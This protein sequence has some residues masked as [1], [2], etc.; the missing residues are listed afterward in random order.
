MIGRDWLRVL[1][2]KLKTE[3]GKCEVNCVNE[4]VNKLF[5]EFKELFSRHEVIEGQEINAQFE[6]NFLPKHQTGTRIPFQLQNFV[7]KELEK[8]I[9]SGNV[10]KVNEIK[11]D[12]FVHYSKTR[13]NHKKSA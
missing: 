11:D 3:G 13:S 9:K 7:K 5:K 6:E 10:E 12:V 1:G 2:V 4:P 8:I